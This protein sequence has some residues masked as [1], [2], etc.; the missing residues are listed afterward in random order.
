MPRLVTH[1]PFAAW[2]FQLYLHMYHSLNP[3]KGVIYGSI[4]ASTMG[5]IIR[6][7]TRSLEYS[8]CEPESWEQLDLFEDTPHRKLLVAVTVFDA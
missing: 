4:Y 1:K 7:D 6:G 5:V 2:T 8:S 3:F